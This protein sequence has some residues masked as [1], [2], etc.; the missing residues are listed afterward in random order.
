MKM[1]VERKSAV[2]EL[3]ERTGWPLKISARGYIAYL[4]EEQKLNEG[5]SVPVYR[6]PGGLSLVDECEMVEVL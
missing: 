6:F 3:H 1:Y 4:A 5:E 2:Q